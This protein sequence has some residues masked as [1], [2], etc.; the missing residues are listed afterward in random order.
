MRHPIS[1]STALLLWLSLA[2]GAQAQKPTFNEGLELKRAQKLGEAAAVFHAVLK[3]EPQNVDAMVQLATVEGWQRHYDEAIRWWEKA[4]AI[5]PDDAD[6]GVGLARVHYWKG[7]QG[8]AASILQQVLERHPR[9]LDALMLMGDVQMARGDAGGARGYYLRAAKVDADAPD[10]KRKLANAQTPLRWRFDSGISFDDY[11]PGRG[12]GEHSFFSQLGYQLPRGT[13]WVRHQQYNFFNQIDNGVGFGGSARMGS[14]TVLSGEIEVIGEPDFQPRWKLQIG[15]DRLVRDWT[16]SG[17]YRRW[18]YP[19]GVV[20]MFLPGLRWQARPWV[21]GMFRYNISRN[22][23][24][25]VT[26]AWQLQGDFQP[27][28]RV[29][30]YAGYARGEEN[31]P[32]QARAEFWTIAG[33]AS[34]SPHRRLGVRLDYSYEHRP[35]FWDRHSIGPGV[36]ISF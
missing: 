19:F 8:D 2:L 28:E 12:Q 14:K 15:G 27:A 35:V 5:R 30:L 7:E 21:A 25:S 31:I 34:W 1:K 24:Q 36:R 16:I 10:L 3:D 33:G 20:H 32:P 4:H 9:Y 6:I 23:D 18:E 26:G 22:I 17:A 13:I 11:S 29:L